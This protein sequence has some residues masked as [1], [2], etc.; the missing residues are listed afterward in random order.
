MV[1]FEEPREL[2]DIRS[3]VRGLMEGYGD[4]YWRAVN[5]EARF[6]SEFWDDLTAGDWLGVAIPEA[7]GGQDMGLLAV[8]AII[9]EM[10]LGGGWSA[11]N[12][13]ART[14]IFGAGTL[15]EHGSEEQKKRWLS[16]VVDGEAKFS[17]AVTEPDTGLNTVT[18]DTRAEL[19]GDGY[20]LDGTKTWIS[21]VEQ[22]DRLILLAR[23]TP[24][25][26]VEKPTRGI[27][28][29]LVDPS[30]TGVSYDEIPMDLSFNEHTYTVYLDDVHVGASRL[31]GEEDEGM[32]QV[33][34]TLNSERITI[35]AHILA[36]G[37][38]AL[39][40]AATYAK[41]REV[42]DAPIG[43]HQAIQHPLAAAQIEL[44]CAR[45]MIQK[46]AWLYDNDVDHDSFGAV[47]NMAKQKAAD[48]AWEACEAAVTTFGGMSAS[49]DIG[50]SK[51]W[52]MVRHLRIAPV[53][54]EMVLNHIA[55]H[56]LGLPR[57]Y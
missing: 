23:T 49:A 56:E 50:I 39:N 18:M 5:E 13:F 48:A 21:G 19:D 57:S 25:E 51:I 24:M 28:I 52:Q 40:M 6:P 20:R 45:L 32:Y 27:S 35:A 54:E 22:A 8:V 47:A 33:F 15:V 38:Y 37:Q 43:S 2:Q 7:Y 1:D 55:E 53:S 41:E 11:T 4:E 29:F 17:L 9:E 44:D 12:K 31:V 14:A 26:A 34:S 16:R 3:A 36:A 46:G 10:G 30:A 42:F